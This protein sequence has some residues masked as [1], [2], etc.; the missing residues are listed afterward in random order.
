V[1]GCRSSH[2]QAKIKIAHRFGKFPQYCRYFVHPRK[3]S[4][5]RS[6]YSTVSS[7]ISEG[8]LPQLTEFHGILRTTGKNG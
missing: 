4:A 1:G 6:Q 8:L 7:R 5:S 2:Q 3:S